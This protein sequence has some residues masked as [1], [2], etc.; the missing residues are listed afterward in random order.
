MAEQAA[1]SAE[2]DVLSRRNALGLAGLGI[3]TTALPAASIASTGNGVAGIGTFSPTLSSLATTA[4]TVGSSHRTNVRFTWTFATTGGGTI[5]AIVWQFD[6]AVLPSADLR[7]TPRVSLHDDVPDNPGN[8]TA[9]AVGLLGV[10]EPVDSTYDPV[11]ARI[12]LVPTAPVTLPAGSTFYAQYYGVGANVSILWTER[13]PDPWA[14][15]VA[16]WTFEGYQPSPSY[17]Y[18]PVTALG[19]LV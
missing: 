2:S 8:T 4:V 12:T 6:P 10:F 1:R 19:I 16:G 11:T 7:I 18:A 13:T 15:S 14:A 5:G 9:S 3:V 17:P